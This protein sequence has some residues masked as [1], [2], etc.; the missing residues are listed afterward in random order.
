MDPITA[1]SQGIGSI[2]DWLNTGRVAKYGRLPQWQN[3]NDYNRKNKTVHTIL[4]V[5]GVMV[6]IIVVGVII[7]SR[8]K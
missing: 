5:M 7:V 4:I 6:M 8:K 1:V 2:F 3:V